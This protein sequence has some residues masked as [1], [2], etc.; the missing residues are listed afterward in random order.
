MTRVGVRRPGRRAL[1]VLRAD[2]DVA[3]G[4][5]LVAREIQDGRRGRVAGDAHEAEL[6]LAAPERH[7]VLVDDVGEDARQRRDLGRELLA[8]GEG[9]LF[10]ARISGVSGEPSGACRS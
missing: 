9:L 7:L 1:A 3:G 6:A 5:D 4:E 10:L 8:P 2:E